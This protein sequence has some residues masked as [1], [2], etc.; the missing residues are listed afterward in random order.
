M[1]RPKGTRPARNHSGWGPSR[2][3]HRRTPPAASDRIRR[4]ASGI[5]RVARCAVRLL[6]V[7]PGDGPVVE[8]AR[9]KGWPRLQILGGHFHMLVAP[10]A[11]AEALV[12]L[13]AKMSAAFPSN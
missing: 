9:S 4:A 3:V 2:A 8:Q 13:V 11:V 1:V 12:R 6:E 10:D 7:Q 5:L